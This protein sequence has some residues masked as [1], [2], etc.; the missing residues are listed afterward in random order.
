MASITTILGM[1]TLL[2][3]SHPMILAIGQTLFI[4]MS[5]CLISCLLV[6][7]LFAERTPP[8]A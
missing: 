6:T 1:L 5:A 8:A 7:P 4:G 2:T 3:T